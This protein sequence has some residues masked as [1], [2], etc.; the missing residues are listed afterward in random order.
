M[1]VESS[2]LSSS[3]LSSDDAAAA[4]ASAL[5]VMVDVGGVLFVAEG[6][7]VGIWVGEEVAEAF[8]PGSAVERL[9]LT[10]PEK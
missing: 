4:A 7:S 3:S 5:T 2:S 1:L 8:S 10:V 9:A 6:V